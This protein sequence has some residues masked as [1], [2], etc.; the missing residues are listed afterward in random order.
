MTT[1]RNHL[2]RGL[3]PFRTL[4]IDAGSR[5]IGIGVTDAQVPTY[6]LTLD[7]QAHRGSAKA[8]REKVRVALGRMLADLRPSVVAIE[9]PTNQTSP[10]MRLVQVALD[11]IVRLV[12][13]SG[14]K[15]VWISP[16]TARLRVTGYGWSDKFQVAAVLAQRFPELR[17]YLLPR[18]SKQIAR[19]VHHSSDA[20]CVALAAGRNGE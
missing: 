16:K 2:H 1:R 7:C 6:W 20:L 15:L 12:R 10:R 18:K 4:G 17:G 5:W 14:A 8:L 19:F 13:G 11:E 9:E 3:V